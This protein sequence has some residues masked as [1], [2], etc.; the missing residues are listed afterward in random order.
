[1]RYIFGLLVLAALLTRLHA[2][3]QSIEYPFCFLHDC[4]TYQNDASVQFLKLLVPERYDEENSTKIEIQGIKLHALSDDKKRSPIL[5]IQGGP[6]QSVLEKQIISLLLNHPFRQD[7]DIYFFDFRGIGYSNPID[8]PE[9]QDKLA[10]FLSQDLTPEQATVLTNDAYKECFDHLNQIGLNFNAYNSVNIVRDYESIRRALGIE[11]WNVWGVSY[12]TRVAQTYMRDFPEAVRTAILDSPVPV[13]YKFWGQDQLSYKESLDRLFEFCKKD[14]ECN[15]K[16]PDLENRFYSIM[17]DYRGKPVRISVPQVDEPVW[18]NYQDAHVML[19]QMLY[20]HN[21]YPIFPWIVESFEKRSEEF[22]SNVGGTVFSILYGHNSPAQRI[23]VK[24]DNGSQVSDFVSTAEHPL[25]DALNFF[26]ND[27]RFQKT[28]FYIDQPEQ[29]KS[30]FTSDIPSLILTGEFDPITP[31]F[32]GNILKQSLPNSFL[33]EFPGRGH[34]VSMGSDCSTDISLAFLNNPLVEPKGN[35]VLASSKPFSWQTEIY[36]NPKIASLLTGI[37]KGHDWLSISALGLVALS[38]LWFLIM[39]ISRL[40][41]RKVNTSQKAGL[42]NR[43]VQI[44]VSFAFLYFLG[45]AWMIISTVQ[46]NDVMILVGLVPQVRIF[47]YA[48]IVVIALTGVVLLLLIKHFRSNSASFGF[49]NT[50]SAIGL[51][52][53]CAVIY[54]FQLFPW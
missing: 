25:H 49:L 35:C 6:G 3:D 26:D 23:I 15:G 38:F 41:R 2:Q 11:K 52:L 13:A 39:G 7:H 45:L 10:R 34:S 43:S 33:F 1:M 40:F 16:F 54:Q 27:F 53:S 36:F 5:F 51:I 24:A 21:F 47:F 46:T 9:L 14:P 32:L 28:L 4:S 30:A 12:G 50:L 44:A 20:Y 8:C 37:V 48:S 17:N 31:P 19:H 22:L 18:V 42:V 29:E